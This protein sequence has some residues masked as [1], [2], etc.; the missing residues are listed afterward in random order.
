M[1][2]P[3]SRSRVDADEHSVVALHGLFEDAQTTWTDSK[4]G[5]LWLRDLFPS[6]KLRARVLL[7]QYDAGSLVS[8]SAASGDRILPYASTF[9]AQLE[10]DRSLRN[11][12]E[13]PIV[14]VCHGFGGI[15]LKRALIMSNASRDPK[16]HHRRAIFVSTYAILFLS[17]PHYGIEKEAL[18]MRCDAF[19]VTPNQF[20][21]NVMSGSELLQDI[22]DQFAPLSK[23]IQMYYFWEQQRTSYGKQATFIVSEQSAAPVWDDVDRCGIQ[24]DH[25]AMVKFSNAREPGYRVVLGALSRYCRAASEPIR[26]RWSHDREV[27]TNEIRMEAEEMLRPLMN[28]P[29]PKPTRSRNMNEWFLVPRAPINYFTGRQSHAQTVADSLGPTSKQ[30]LR[31]Q[32][33]IFVIY[34]LGGSG[35]TQFCLKYVEDH[36]SM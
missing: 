8:N 23:S 28:I 18:L 20:M 22:N 1:R 31:H 4:T 2:L 10:A 9:L 7:Y 21:L 5:I 29:S 36:R 15:L 33:K 35:K 11:A 3:L 13:R 19:N 14:F 16:V 34:G 30:T 24:A 32:H 25:S 26:M 6:T 12:A 17:T 27:F